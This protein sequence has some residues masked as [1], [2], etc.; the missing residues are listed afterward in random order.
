MYDDIDFELAMVRC[1]VGKL[2]PFQF[3]SYKRHPAFSSKPS[4]LLVLI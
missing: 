3:S 2:C 4:L 1:V